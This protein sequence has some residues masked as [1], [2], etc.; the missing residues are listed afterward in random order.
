MDDS[1]ILL[2]LNIIL[3]HSPQQ[4]LYFCCGLYNNMDFYTEFKAR[5][6]YY[7][8]GKILS[9]IKFDL[10]HYINYLIIVIQNKQTIL[11][12][13][14]EISYIHNLHRI[15]SGENRIDLLSFLSGLCARENW[16][17]CEK[18]GDSYIIGRIID[19]KE[20]RINIFCDFLLETES[21]IDIED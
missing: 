20:D 7:I 15:L 17:E 14:N 16:G 9:D 18:Y 6:K 11:N 5:G 8:M 21:Q 1:T 10:C 19:M 13:Q 12:S 3:L 2:N 4:F